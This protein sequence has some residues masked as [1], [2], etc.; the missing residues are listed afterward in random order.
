MTNDNLVHT[1][2]KK[3][4]RP[5]LNNNNNV[6]MKNTKSVFSIMFAHISPLQ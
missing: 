5:Q 2:L 6:Q 3:Y 4:R 1:T